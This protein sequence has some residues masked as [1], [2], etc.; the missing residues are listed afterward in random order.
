MQ[1]PQIVP[2]RGKLVIPLHQ[3]VEVAAHLAEFSEQALLCKLSL[4]LVFALTLA[5][6]TELGLWLIC[7]LG[8]EAA[9]EVEMVDLV[10]WRTLREARRLGNY[11]FLFVF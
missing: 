9:L 3:V 11:V 2:R 7:Q 5:E 4:E 10:E 1:V 6:L 8:Q